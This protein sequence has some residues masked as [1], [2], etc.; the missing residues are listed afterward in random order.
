VIAGLNSIAILPTSPKR[1]PAPLTLASLVALALLLTTLIGLVIALVIPGGQLKW[2]LSPS[3]WIKTL[4]LISSTQWLGLLAWAA[5]TAAL[6]ALGV[7]T[8]P[9]R[10]YPRWFAV[11]AGAFVP[12][13]LVLLGQG[14][15]L[16]WPEIRDTTSPFDRPLL[17]LPL[18]VY[19]LGASWLLGCL[20][21]TATSSEVT[22]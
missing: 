18:L 7:G 10:S 11:A 5:L 17:S 22:P 14:V 4:A 12:I 16:L 19:G 1:A 8:G 15:G 2:L 6:F 9:T 3:A 21:R 13:G 20:A